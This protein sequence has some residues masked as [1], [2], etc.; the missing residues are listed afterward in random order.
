MMLRS[1]SLIDARSVPKDSVIDFPASSPASIFRSKSAWS[2]GSRVS[3]IARAASRM[4]KPAS[5][6]FAISV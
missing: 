4:P 1:S 5:T 3:S 6:I 2:D